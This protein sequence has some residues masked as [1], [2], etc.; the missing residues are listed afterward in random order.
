MPQLPEMQIEGGERHGHERD[1]VGRVGQVAEGSAPAERYVEVR[2]Q[3]PVNGR[4]RRPRLEEREVRGAREARDPDAA[5]AEAR[6]EAR[7]E[8][9]QEGDQPLRGRDQ[10]DGQEEVDREIGELAADE[11]PVVPA[12]V[13]DVERERR[14]RDGRP[15]PEQRAARD[16]ARLCSPLGRRGSRVRRHAR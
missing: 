12:Q 6:I 4:E 9:A 15:D 10:E 1:Q 14:G 7:P 2:E 13:K 16:I 5:R 3:G 8:E 11:A